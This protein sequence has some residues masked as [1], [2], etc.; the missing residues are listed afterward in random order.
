MRQ[1]VHVFIP[2]FFFSRF[3]FDNTS[4]QQPVIIQP[5]AYLQDHIN[6]QLSHWVAQQ[7]ETL[8]RV[9]NSFSPG[10]AIGRTVPSIKPKQL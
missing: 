10:H 3:C 5:K 1:S 4:H 2:S 6:F 9:Q 7:I 8:W